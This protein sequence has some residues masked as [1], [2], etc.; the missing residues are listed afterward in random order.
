ML[1]KSLVG[2]VPVFFAGALLALC[3]CSKTAKPVGGTGGA[4]SST[5]TSS[6]SSGGD[7]GGSGGS[8]GAGGGGQGGSGGGAQGG[9]GGA[10]STA[11]EYEGIDLTKVPFNM[12]PDGCVG[13][14][15]AASQKLTLTLTAKVSVVLIG[16]V[17]DVIQANG[18]PCFVDA[19]TQATTANTRALAVIGTA[20][21]ESV[22]VDLSTGPFGALLTAPGGGIHVDLGGG[23][24]AFS[25]RGSPGADKITAGTVDGA[26]ALDLDGDGKPDTFVVGAG[27][28][29]VSLGPGN[30]VFHGSGIGGGPALTHAVTVHGGDGKD[31]LEGG[32]GDDTL[33][34]DA[35]D[36]TFLTAATADG[37][38]TYDGGEGRDTVDYSKRSAPLSVSIDGAANDG[39][40][41]E[42]DNVTSTIEVLIGGSGDD[43]LVGGPGDDTIYGG[44]GNDTIVGGPGNDELHGE[45]GNDVLHG[46]DG[47]D[48]L[49]GDA[50][51]DELYGDAGDDL[52]DSGTGKDRLDGGAGD[53]D[54]CVSKQSD[55][56][57]GC[58]V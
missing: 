9:S 49:Y 37:A 56:I 43:L 54:I 41:G 10:A 50:G 39:A 23:Q 40:S 7:A 6:S 25:L 29:T 13:G 57:T 5:A 19:A 20:A 2:R 28:L 17:G 12:A 15:D 21:D 1:R 48:T 24:N 30:D 35:G 55:L 58:E 34:G 32:A 31:T 11:A 33:Y 8:G 14:F 38:D 22:I 27:T 53:G 47:E 44:P 45:A 36:D 42:H 3:A 46:G 16:V 4:T 26:P 52:L 51:D 18:V